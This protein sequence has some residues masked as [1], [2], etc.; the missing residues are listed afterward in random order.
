MQTAISGIGSGI[1]NL[2]GGGNGVDGT[3]HA[4]GTAYANGTAGK[5]FAQGN[6]GT[7]ENGVALGG[8]L[9][10][11]LLVR[12]GHWYTIGE[13]SAEFFGYK[14]GDIIFNADQ[15]REIFE[16]GKITHGNGRG[17]A[18]AEGTA[19]SSGSGGLG[20]AS[21]SKKRSSSSSSKKSSSGSSSKSSG[22]SSSSSSGSSDEA[23]KFEEQIDWI[24]IAI[25][26]IERAISRLDLKATSVFKGW[27]ER[28][29]ALNNQISQTTKEISL[30]E[31]AYN[32]YMQEANKVGLSENYASKV[33]DGTIDI[34]TITDEDLN[35]KISDY[36]EWYLIMPTYP[37]MGM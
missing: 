19:F 22:S 14:K 29:S 30:Q 10:T 25:D 37:V 28:T 18:L 3:A 26:R 35:D 27:T 15:T 32:R 16:K 1:K 33:R 36:K 17:R 23:D 12:N 5:A 34:E 4:N 21:S 9:G 13:D 8:E 11:E 20:R 6:W 31:S 2:F 24:E 7:K